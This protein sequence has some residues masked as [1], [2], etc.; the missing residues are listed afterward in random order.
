MTDG[1][2]LWGPDTLVWSCS[3]VISILLRISIMNLSHEHPGRSD[4]AQERSGFTACALN[5][6]HRMSPLIYNEK[7]TTIQARNHISYNT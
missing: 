6:E 1:A 4:P 5:I 2:R 7:E 3:G